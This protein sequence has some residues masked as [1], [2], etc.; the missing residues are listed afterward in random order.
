MAKNSKRRT[1]PLRHAFRFK[2]EATGKV[3]TFWAKVIEAKRDVYLPLKAEHVRE[4]IRLKGVGNTQT[5]AMAVCA[6]RE[7]EA[8]SH[9][10]EGY[11]DWT[12]TRAWVVSQTDRNGM[13]SIC[14]VYEHSDGIGRLNDTPG[15]QRQLLAELVAEGGERI[16]HLRAPSKSSGKNV[17]KDTRGRGAQDGSRSRVQP[18]GAKQRFAFAQAGAVP[19]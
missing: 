16:V 9:P 3:V 1:R 18:R 2:I 10:V 12:Y 8:F 6:R 17:K 13:P 11:I 19:A 14:Y 7:K 15:G 4:S 5:C